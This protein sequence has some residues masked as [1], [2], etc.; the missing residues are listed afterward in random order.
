MTTLFQAVGTA[1]AAAVAITALAGA[2]IGYLICT[3]L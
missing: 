2:V 1:I 3:A